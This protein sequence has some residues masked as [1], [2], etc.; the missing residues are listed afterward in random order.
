M[1][2]PFKELMYEKCDIFIP[3]ACEKVI[4][5]GNA[6]RIQANVSK[7]EPHNLPHRHYY[8][9]QRTQKL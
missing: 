9:A 2:E 8:R 6:D 7:V 5:K 4:H 3:A 1:F